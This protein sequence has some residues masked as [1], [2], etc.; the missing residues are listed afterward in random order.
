AAGP[1]SRRRHRPLREDRSD[2]RRSV[3]RTGDRA[4][5]QVGQARP[6]GGRDREGA[7]SPDPA[8][9]ARAPGSRRHRAARRRLPAARRR[10]PRAR[11]AAQGRGGDAAGRLPHRLPRRGHV[12]VDG[13]ER[14]GDGRATRRPD[15]HRRR[16]ARSARRRMPGVVRPLVHVPGGARVNEQQIAAVEATGE[17]F[18]SAG[19]GTGKT[20]VLVERFARAVCDQGLDVGS[21]L[22]ITYTRR[23]AGELRT[24]IRAEL[25]SRGRHDL[26]RELDGAWISTIHG[27]CLRLLK[28]YPF[29][30]G[31]DPRFRE[32]DDA[33]AAVLRSEAFE[34]ALAEFCSGGEP[35][36]LQLLATYGAAG[37]RR[38]LT[39]VYETLRSAGRELVLGVG[40]K[41]ELAERVEEL[42]DTARALGGETADQLL[43]LLERD[44]RPDRLLDLSGF[45]IK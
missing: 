41:P 32:L 30:A 7:A 35:D 28:T 27:F 21:I 24:R 20:A 17:V 9:H 43:A 10:A 26:A 1:R 16:R 5:L 34:R 13:C 38:M 44:A 18:V 19:A 36:R 31:L 29:A 25:A 8:V 3:Q 2:R 39:G 40:D 4:G 15:P 45:R 42:R 37:L 33:Q 23:A 11:A 6:L 12:L 22:V 14:G